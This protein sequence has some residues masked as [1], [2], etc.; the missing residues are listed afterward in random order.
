MLIIPISGIIIIIG[1]ISEIHIGSTILKMDSM[2]M[3]VKKVGTMKRK[4]LSLLLSVS[5]VMSSVAVYADEI[6]ETTVVEEQ[7]ESS[8]SED[9]E[10][11]IE[12]TVVEVSAAETPAPENTTIEEPVPEAITTEEPASGVASPE[13]TIPEETVVPEPVSEPEETVASET[14]SEPEE[15]VAPENVSGR[16]EVV[17]PET[18]SEPEETVASE[19]VSEP[20]EV[21]APENVSRQEDTTSESG[22]V[23]GA[24]VEKSEGTTNKDAVAASQETEKVSAPEVKQ[25]VETVTQGS[26]N[27]TPLNNNASDFNKT[28]LDFLDGISDTYTKTAE[29]ISTSLSSTGRYNVYFTLTEINDRTGEKKTYNSTLSGFKSEEKAQEYV[30]SL[31]ANKNATLNLL[32]TYSDSELIDAEKRPWSYWVDL[33]NDP[34]TTIFPPYDSNLCWAGSVADMLELTGWNKA[35]RITP[36]G[37]ILSDEDYVYDLFANNF[38]DLAGNQIYGVQWFFN[39]INQ[40]QTRKNWSHLKSEEGYTE[41]FLK[42]YC[43]DN[44][45]YSVPYPTKDGLV[46]GLKTLDYDEDGDRCAIGLV[47]GYYEK[48]GNRNGGHCV[49]IVGYSTDENGVPNSITIADSDSYNGGFPGYSEFGDRRT[50][51]NTYSTYPIEFYDGYWHMMNFCDDSYDTKI[52]DLIFLKYYSDNTKNKIEKDGTKDLINFYDLYPGYERTFKDNISEIVDTVYQGDLLR[53]AFALMDNSICERLYADRISYRFI[54]SKDGNVIRVIDNAEE[55]EEGET[56]IGYYYYLDIMDEN[57]SLEPGEY[58]IS[59]VV[60]YDKSVEEAYYNN[61]QSRK[62]IRFIVLKRVD[63]SGE[64]SYVVV[65]ASDSDSDNNIVKEFIQDVI[66]YSMETDSLSYYINPEKVF[67]FHFSNGF[68]EVNISDAD[69]ENAEIVFDYS[70]TGELSGA[71]GGFNGN[72]SSNISITKDDFKIIKN[73]DGTVSIVFTND[74]MRKLP[75]GTHYFKLRIGGKVRIFKIEVK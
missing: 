31:C 43:V 24:D 59:F 48:N 18:V 47:F 3:I 22:E 29:N 72:I 25:V 68:S 49:T 10:G 37:S 4:L 54:I 52:D 17:A 15:V 23:S 46:D 7:Q 71:N 62:P 13:V 74:F 58:Y 61:N 60:N 34:S 57:N 64:E 28:A 2:N 14:V 42:D 32:V 63:E 67:E 75:K 5:I 12:I 26:K 9:S 27:A 41:G 40:V 8:D 30:S 21:I 45:A 16:E 70:V 73:A 50:Y 19:P 56:G 33:E 11:Y 6:E 55:V 39:G 35:E 1:M 44:F 53:A 20:E 66:D 36:H 51:I 65:P 38:T 69:I